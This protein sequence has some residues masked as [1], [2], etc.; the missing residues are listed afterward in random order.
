VNA[1]LD[2]TI[3]RNTSALLMGT[4]NATTNYWFPPAQVENPNSLVTPTT[5][6]VT[7]QYYLYAISDYRCTNVDSV[8][9]TI[10]P[11]TIVLLPTGFSPNGDG[12]NDVFRIAK[13]LNIKT[14]VSFAV[15][16]RWGERVFETNDI[17]EGWDG[18][19]R[20]QMQEVSTYVWYVNAKTY[21]GEDLV[22]SGNVTLVR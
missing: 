14:L 5:P 21:E 6:L 2:T 10:D 11:R 16:N 1:G 19:Y 3:Y 9:V 15:Y 20:G 13:A 7:T 17:N 8:I 12:V 4:S 18:V 22:R